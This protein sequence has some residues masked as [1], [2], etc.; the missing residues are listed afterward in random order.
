LARPQHKILRHDRWI[1]FAERTVTR[2]AIGNSLVKEVTMSDCSVST[3]AGGQVELDAHTLQT[4]ASSLDGSLLDRDDPGY[5][6]ARAV[7]NAMVEKRPAL[8]ARC[9]GAADV[10]RSLDFARQHGLLFSI[11]GAGHNI[12][13]SGL[14]E[15][16]LTIDLSLL[17]AVDVDLESGT[18]RVQPGAT[19]GDV[20]AATL[21]HGLAI[22]VG[23]NSTTGIAGLTLGGGF[24]W[25]SRKYGLTIDSLLS[26]DVV[27]AAGE[28]ITASDTE[29]PDLFWGLKGGG[30]NFGIVT[31]FDFR[32]RDAGPDLLCGLIVHPFSEGQNVL[33]TWREF[34]AGASDDM[35]V[36]AVLRDAPPLPFLPE[37]VHGTKVVILAFV[38][39]G[40]PADGE[41]ELEPLRAYGNPHGEH[42]GVMPFA[43][44]QQ[45]FDPLLTPGSRNYWKS[46]NF[47][48]IEDGL[49][50]T[51]LE[52]TA[53]LP[54]PQSEIFIAQVGGAAARIPADSGAYPHRDAAFVM[55]VHT[56]WEDAADDER[57]V[58][59][60]REFFD[61]TAGFATGGVYMNFV[62]E[63]EDET[64]VEAAYGANYER[65]RQLKAKYDP[66]NVFRTNLNVRP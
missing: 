49:I 50:D 65:L 20:D 4:F 5:E 25:L 57:C 6:E 16:G 60:A 8:I 27:T 3:L 36:W 45:A 61:A 11:R 26:A 34:V 56:R 15:G 12:A 17:R 51:L 1:G 29:N 33:E 41:R 32:L 7:W 22:P 14:C 18:A 30:G 31:S 39:A 52:Y 2:N 43:E 63:A 40:D 62:S 23:I 21:P 64:R 44:F 66:D 46:H 55:N 38:Y 24:G 47:S 48:G 53:A 19:L 28:E 42:I 59:W 58:A 37:E 54:S 13:G 10:K 9:A 35:T